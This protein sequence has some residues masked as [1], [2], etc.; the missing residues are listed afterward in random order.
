METPKIEQIRHK[1]EGTFDL[2]RALKEISLGIFSL[3]EQYR[4]IFTI[5]AKEPATEYQIGKVGKK[6]GLDRDSVRRR[7]LG[8]SSL[9]SLEEVEFLRTKTD[10]FRT[11]KQTK[12]YSLTLK[13]IS[14]SLSHTTFEDVFNIRIFK[15][16]IRGL[17][18]N[19]FNIGDLIVLYAK[20]HT[21]LVLS[22]YRM[23]NFD[24]TKTISLDSLFSKSSMRRILF[25]PIPNPTIDIK[26]YQTYVEIGKRFL[27]VRHVIRQII[28]MMVEKKSAKMFTS[29]ALSKFPNL[30]YQSNK[31]VIEFV[32]NMLIRHWFGYVNQA[33]ELLR[34][35]YLIHDETKNDE[36][37]ITPMWLKEKSH[38]QNLAQSVFDTLNV[39]NTKK[40]KPYELLELYEE[41]LKKYFQ[42][43]V[44]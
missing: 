4:G 32:E 7:L 35:E 33:Q 38:M 36:E 2:D 6:Y 3:D 39:K 42:M 5:L 30:D 1:L 11:G 12:R 10:P 28:S 8:T 26:N 17:T 37:E 34:T 21:A 29:G 9:P 14:A 31:E 25:D 16:I 23:N 13:G 24:I 44:K 15:E 27:V 20:Y 41:K 40:I 43:K 19:Q 22:W 18:D